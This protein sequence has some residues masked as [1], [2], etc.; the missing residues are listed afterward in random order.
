MVIWLIGLA[1]SGKSTAGKKLYEKIKKVDNA[2]VLVDGDEIRKI[3]NHDRGDDPYSI[4]GRRVNAERISEICKWLDNQNIN[5]VCCILS[6]FEENREWNRINYENYYEIY[7]KAKDK[8]LYRRRSIYDDAIS[9]RIN[10]V[11][12]ID[13]PFDEPKNPDL[14]F[15]TSL[16][17]NTPEYI[18]QT[19]LDKIQKTL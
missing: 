16:E 15:N 17:V 6:I 1:G 11:V 3:F 18:T 13:I 4:E 14:T 2:T 9:G 19:I 7:F 5:V 10:N 8:D 12:G